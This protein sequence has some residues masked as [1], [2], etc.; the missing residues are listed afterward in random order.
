MPGR[1]ER[2]GTCQYRLKVVLAACD[3]GRGMPKPL[4]YV[5][6]YSRDKNQHKLNFSFSLTLTHTTYT[7]VVY[8]LLQLSGKGICLSECEFP[9][10][11]NSQ[12]ERKY[13]TGRAPLFISVFQKWPRGQKCVCMCMLVY[14]LTLMTKRVN[15]EAKECARVG[16]CAVNSEH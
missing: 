10:K 8:Q 2:V 3:S 16:V 13:T 4:G 9:C 15:V 1:C 12:T 5:N 7:S 14:S 11:S 6:T